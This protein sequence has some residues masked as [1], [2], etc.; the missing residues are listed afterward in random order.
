MVLTKVDVGMGITWAT[1][2]YVEN[3]KYTNNTIK[4]IT[5]IFSMNNNIL[6]EDIVLRRVLA[7][8]TATAADK[9]GE[10]V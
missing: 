2:I 10:D 4:Q 9:A 6:T 5:R 1:I 3:T 8:T 7:T